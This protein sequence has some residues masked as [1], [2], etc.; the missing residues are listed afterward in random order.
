MFY[1]YRFFRK[2]QLFNLFYDR[3]CLLS[4]IVILH[5]FKVIVYN[6]HAHSFQFVAL[7]CFFLMTPFSKFLQIFFN[8]SSHFH[9][10]FQNFIHVNPFPQFYLGPSLFP[11]SH[12]HQEQFVLPV[13]SCMYDPHRSVN[14]PLNKNAFSSPSSYPLKT[15]PQLGVELGAHLLH[16]HIGCGLS[17]CRLSQ[18]PCELICGSVLLGPENTVSLQSPTASGFGTLS[19]YSSLMIPAA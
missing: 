14:T 6:Q 3:L 1:I 17:L 5:T 4:Y 2:I 7:I 16:L 8:L 13:D 12:N 19:A 15:D 18:I 11:Y 9:Q 10:F